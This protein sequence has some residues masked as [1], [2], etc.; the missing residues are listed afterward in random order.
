MLRTKTAPDL[1]GKI[2]QFYARDKAQE[3]KRP[4]SSAEGVMA[5]APAHIF[6]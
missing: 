1:L 2:T 3:Q 5:G 4:S 6:P